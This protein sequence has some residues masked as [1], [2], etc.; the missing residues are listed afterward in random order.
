MAT[1]KV[2]KL[3]TIYGSYALY[4]EHNAID[5]KSGYNV[6]SMK[7]SSNVEWTMV[8]SW[9]ALILSVTVLGISIIMTNY[10]LQRYEIIIIVL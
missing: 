1:N 6:A 3:Q 10:Q 4:E 9:L 2:S 7:F 8:S 5:T